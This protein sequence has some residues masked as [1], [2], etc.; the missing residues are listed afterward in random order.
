MFCM[1]VKNQKK[2]L[3]HPMKTKRLRLEKCLG[4]ARQQCGV[5]S[6]QLQIQQGSERSDACF[7]VMNGVRTRHNENYTERWQVLV[8][9][10][11]V[12][13]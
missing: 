1:N 4:K 6:A 13:E 2:R 3:Q 5:P 10:N 8:S 12:D 11:T 9:H 7:V